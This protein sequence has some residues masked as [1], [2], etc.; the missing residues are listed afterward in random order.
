MSDLFDEEDMEFVN[1]GPALKSKGKKGA[2]RKEKVRP[3]APVGRAGACRVMSGHRHMRIHNRCRIALTSLW[4]S[5]GPVGQ[6]I[7]HTMTSTLPVSAY[8]PYVRGC[9]RTLQCTLACPPQHAC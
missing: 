6:P 8:K 3:G 9:T 1:K 2:K 5:V 7:A 4:A